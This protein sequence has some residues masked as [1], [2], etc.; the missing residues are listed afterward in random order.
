MKV[1]IFGANGM[2]GN[3]LISTI[4]KNSLFDIYG[5]IR[6]ESKFFIANKNIKI[7]KNAYFSS[8]A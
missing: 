1:L 6:N 7:F 3:M 2:L 5:T 4:L 8:R